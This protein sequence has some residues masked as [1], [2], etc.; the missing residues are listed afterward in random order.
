[1]C[2]DPAALGLCRPPGHPPTAS[3]DRAIATKRLAADMITDGRFMLVAS[4]VLD[5]GY[6]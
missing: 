3:A 6:T 5:D 1:M 4:T 2:L